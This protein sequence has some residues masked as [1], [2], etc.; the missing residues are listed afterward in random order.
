M[1]SLPLL[2]SLL[3]SISSAPNTME[4]NPWKSVTQNR[5]S[6]IINST[7][8]ISISTCNNSSHCVK[9]ITTIGKIIAITIINVNTIVTSLLTQ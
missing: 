8:I 7:I 4:G 9:S 1:F 5:S 2:L 6:I 3:I